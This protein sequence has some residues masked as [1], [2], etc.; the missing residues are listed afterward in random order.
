MAI[1][2][3]Y[4]MRGISGS[5]K[6]TLARILAGSWGNVHSADDYHMCDGRY[7]FDRSRLKEYHDRCFADFCESLRSEVPV[8]VC[9]NVNC[10]RGHFARYIEV[11][12]E[13]GYLVAVVAIP[14]PP[15]EVAVRRNVHQVPWA[16]ISEMLAKWE[17]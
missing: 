14:H 2:I 15:L 16:D 5:G 4:I 11:A 6:T 17:A 12:E 8:V 9:D 1:K 3:A 10:L 13:A 7:V